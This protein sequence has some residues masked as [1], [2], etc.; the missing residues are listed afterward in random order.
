MYNV[1]A[2]FE[3]ETL[4]LGVKGEFRPNARVDV[5]KLIED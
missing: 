1:C 5:E 4:L 2:E 3:Y